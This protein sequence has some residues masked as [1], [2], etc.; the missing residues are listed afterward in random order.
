MTAL[1]TDAID[2]ELSCPA[3][4]DSYDAFGNEVNHTG[5]T[6]NN[7]LYRGEQ[8]DPDLGLYYLRARYYNPL[9]GRFMSRD[10][11]DPKLIDASGNP[12]DPRMLHKYLFAGGDPVN[13][14]D[15]SGKEAI[16]EYKF[17]IGNI[18][19]RVALDPANHPFFTLVGKLYFCIHLQL[20]LWTIG[21][22]GSGWVARV[23]LIP[24]CV[25]AGP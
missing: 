24:L 11:F 2:E 12:V 5:T 18:G 17:N 25:A 7:Y 20:N 1:A 10:P 4:I 6:P 16:F 3:V 13:W 23:P 14:L 19:V 15:P 22:K 21:V 8:Y 9:T